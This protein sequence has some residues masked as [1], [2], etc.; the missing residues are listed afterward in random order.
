LITS[1]RRAVVAKAAVARTVVAR[2]VVAKAARTVGIPGA[3][4]CVL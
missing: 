2:T 1:R 3:T 4:K